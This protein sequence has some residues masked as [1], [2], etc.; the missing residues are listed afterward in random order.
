MCFIFQKKKK[1]KT[2]IRENEEEHTANFTVPFTIRNKNGKHWRRKKSFLQQKKYS[3]KDKKRRKKAKKAV[4]ERN[5][6]KRRRKTIQQVGNNLAF[7][8]VACTEFCLRNIFPY[9]SFTTTDDKKERRN[10]FSFSF[11]SLLE[12]PAIIMEIMGDTLKF[13]NF[14]PLIIFTRS[15]FSLFL[16]YS[17]P[18]NLTT[19]CFLLP[20]HSFFQ[21]LKS[22]L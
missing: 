13:H 7:P 8:F 6:G 12:L 11:S 21:Y 10:K 5:E 1:K 14:F 2:A 16:L 4:V 18:L 20:R 9:I 19:I 3:H 15:S 22:I 17:C